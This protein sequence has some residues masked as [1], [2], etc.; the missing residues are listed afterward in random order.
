MPRWMYVLIVAGLVA[1]GARFIGAPKD[2]NLIDF[3]FDGGFTFSGMFRRPCLGLRFS[4]FHR[5][6]NTFNWNG[7]PVS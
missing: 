7:E 1:V 2:R 3:Y 4:F 5:A 6:P